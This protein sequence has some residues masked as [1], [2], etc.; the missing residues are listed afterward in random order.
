MIDLDLPDGSDHPP[1][2]SVTL[3]VFERWVIEVFIPDA[4]AR[5]E[6]TQESA[7]RD[8][9]ENNEGRMPEFRILE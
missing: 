8:F 9:E 7:I 3:D 5:G 4:I 1:P 2:P 6:L